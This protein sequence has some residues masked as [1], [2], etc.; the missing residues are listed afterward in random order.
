[1]KMPHSLREF[2]RITN[3]INDGQGTLGLLKRYGHGKRPKSNYELCEESS[4]KTSESISNLNKL[5]FLTATII[6]RRHLK[7][8]AVAN[9]IRT[10]KT[11]R[12]ATE[13]NKAVSE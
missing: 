10:I 11:T 7:D 5:T 3:E 13:I 2:T 6:S 1:M 9:S 12:Y 4:K 8:T